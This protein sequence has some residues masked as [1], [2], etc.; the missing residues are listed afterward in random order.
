TRMGTVGV[1]VLQHYEKENV[2]GPRDI[3]FLS[4]VAT[5]LALAIERK[6]SEEELLK[7]EANFRDL[8]DNAPVAYHELDTEGRFTRIN[9]TEEELL[10]YTNEELRGR[11]PWEFIVEKVSRDATAA[12]LT[13][14]VKLLPVERTF[15]RKDG[16]QVPVL[17]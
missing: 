1:L 2:Y 9:H 4:T 6:R 15:I 12:K 13:G 5:Q 14:K 10:G 8:F 16:T 7:S 3:A 17:T 11:H